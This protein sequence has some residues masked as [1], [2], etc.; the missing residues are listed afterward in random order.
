MTIEDKR[1]PGLK[2][3]PP[4]LIVAVIGPAYGVDWLLPL[5]IADSGAL[6]LGG[7]AIVSVALLLALASLIG[8]LENIGPVLLRRDLKFSRDFRFNV[9]KK[10][11]I[12]VATVSS[13]IMLRNYWALV[14]GHITGI[15]EL[16]IDLGPDFLVRIFA[17]GRVNLVVEQGTFTADQVG[18]EI[19]RLEA[20]DHRSRF[21]NATVFELE[22]G[23]TRR[24]VFIGL[25]IFVLRA[26][27]V[28]ADTFH[29]AIH[30][31]EEGVQGMTTGGEQAASPG[32][33]LGIPAILQLL[34]QPNQ[35]KN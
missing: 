22:N 17:P 10:I 14:I 8:G 15:A 19:V 18:M 4:L 13:A 30:T 28:T 20:I 5:P 33:G 23:N 31:Q 1:G 16:H 6:W 2:F 34:L 21:P 11:F 29:L 26:C 32:I 25:E 24:R 35:I 12:F 27:A 3:P 9:H 7:A